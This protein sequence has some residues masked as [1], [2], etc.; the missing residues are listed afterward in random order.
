MVEWGLIYALGK[1]VKNN[2]RSTK[3]QKKGRQILPTLFYYD[4]NI[5]ISQVF[6]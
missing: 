3:K 2:L 1:I 5:V 6:V 4:S